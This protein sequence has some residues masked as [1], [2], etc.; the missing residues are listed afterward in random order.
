MRCFSDGFNFIFQLS[1]PTVRC[2]PYCCTCPAWY[3]TLVTLVFSYQDTETSECSQRVLG[4]RLRLYSPSPVGGTV[5]TAGQSFSL[6]QVVT[7]QRRSKAKQLQARLSESGCS[8]LARLPQGPNPTRPGP[9]HSKAESGLA[10]DRGAEPYF[11]TAG[12]SGLLG[13]WWQ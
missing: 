9:V 11:L 5:P 2:L 12:V 1:L 13:G 3:F 7:C 8:C 4:R 10:T 6:L